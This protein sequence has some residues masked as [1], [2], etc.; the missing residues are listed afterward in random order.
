VILPS[1]DPIEYFCPDCKRHWLAP[2]A[3]ARQQ[4]RKRPASRSDARK[5]KRRK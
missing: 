4:S 5:T 3:P 2:E 1:R